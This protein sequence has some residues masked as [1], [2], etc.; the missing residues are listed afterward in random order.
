MLPYQSSLSWPPYSKWSLSH[1]VP[2]TK[3]PSHML[4]PLDSVVY[5]PH[6][7]ASLHLPSTPASAGHSRSSGFLASGLPPSPR[8][9]I[10]SAPTA[11]GDTISTR[12]SFPT[13]TVPPDPKSPGHGLEYPRSLLSA[14]LDRRFPILSP[15]EV[16]VGKE[17][18]VSQQ[19]ATQ[20]SNQLAPSLPLRGKS[21]PA[22]RGLP[23]RGEGRV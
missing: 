2:L 4:V 20:V 9:P 6:R 12:A 21:C 14:S 8:L 10:T 13:C 7:P 16:E 5:L 15:R 23:G 11:P 18:L 17:A 3:Q 1:F 22:H 19:L